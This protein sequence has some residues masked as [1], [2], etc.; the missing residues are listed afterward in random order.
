MLDAIKKLLLS[1]SHALSSVEMTN[2]KRLVHA[3]TVVPVDCPM[4]K[5]EWSLNMMFCFSFRAYWRGLSFLRLHMYP[6]VKYVGKW[7]LEEM[8]PQTYNI[9]TKL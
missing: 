8:L 6:R 1:F 7:S 2:R 5:N 9:T 4:L 3:D